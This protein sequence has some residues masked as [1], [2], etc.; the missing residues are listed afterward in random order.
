MT[1][2]FLVN[3]D[4]THRVIEFE[5]EHAK[6]FLGGIDSG[7]VS[8]AFQEDGTTY[9]ALYSSEARV[10][11]ADPNPVAS[12]GRAEAETGDSAFFTDPI[13]AIC[14]PVVFVGAEGED[15]GPGEIQRIKKG[16]E[17]VQNYIT[18]AP[19]EYAL[20]RA[21]ARKVSKA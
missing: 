17:A 8:V 15:I 18:D 11:G 20:W 4:Q 10:E 19:E 12:L 14:G 3:P 7:R 6:Q 13:K 2:G 9:A 1:T 16:I 21:A 5:L